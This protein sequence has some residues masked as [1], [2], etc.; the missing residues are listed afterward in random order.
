MAESAS[1]LRSSLPLVAPAL[2]LVAAL[3]VGGLGGVVLGFIALLLVLDRAS[4]LTGWTLADADHVFARL[5]RRRRWEALVGRVR[6]RPA[7]ER[8]LAVLSEAS[9]WAAVADRRRR[10]VEP[11]RLDSIVGTVEPDKATAFDRRFRPPRWTRGRWKGLWL[12]ARRG[13][14][15]PPIS[16]YRVGREHDVRDGH[17]RCRSRAPSVRSRSTPRSSSFTRRPTSLG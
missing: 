10:G 2:L 1:R 4:S 11:I 16:V 3:V 8:H 12:A 15:L 7:A 5:V 14:P 6:R 9:G 17:H 13:N